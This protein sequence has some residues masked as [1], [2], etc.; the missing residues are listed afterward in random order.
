MY[1]QDYSWMDN[2]ENYTLMDQ[3]YRQSW[4]I[5]QMDEDRLN[6]KWDNWNY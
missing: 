4:S 1:K 3:G 2:T 5:T 6:Y